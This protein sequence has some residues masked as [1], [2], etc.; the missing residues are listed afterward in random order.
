MK[1]RSAAAVLM[2]AL[3]VSAARLP[4]AQSRPEQ[5]LRADLMA[6]DNAFGRATAARGIDGWMAYVADDGVFM[7]DG[8]DP[9]RG[10]DA[11]RAFYTPAFARPGYSL[12]WRP[13]DADVARSGDLGYTFGVYES[14]RTDR[15]GKR[16]TSHGKY[17]TIWKKQP[18]GSWKAVIDIG[19][20]GPPVSP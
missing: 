13:T 2:F 19:N 6:T 12:T 16:V 15:D 11:I 10:K 9:V 1:K 17:V 5:S 14:R 8:T 18:D 20:S 7:P 4:I 3:A